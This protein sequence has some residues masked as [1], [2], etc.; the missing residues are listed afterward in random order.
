MRLPTVG[1]SLRNVGCVGIFCRDV[2]RLLASAV[3]V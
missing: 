1:V 2:F 3:E